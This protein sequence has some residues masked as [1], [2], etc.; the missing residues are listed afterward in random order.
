ME[1]RTEW[2]SK[3]LKLVDPD[4][5]WLLFEAGGLALAWGGSSLGARA[6]QEGDCEPFQELSLATGL[7]AWLAW[8]MEIDVRSAVERTS[9]IDLD[10]EDDPWRPIQVFAA[11]AGQLSSDLDA[12]ETFAG[13]VARTV[14][15]DV[16]TGSWIAAHLWL[17][18][19]LAHLVSGR[20]AFAKPA[21]APRP[22]DLILLGP[23]IDLRVR[24]AL[25]VVPAGAI[26]R[27]SVLAPEVEEGERQ[28]HSTHVQYLAWWEKETVIRQR[29]GS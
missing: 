22:G 2:R 20:E 14:R 4:H 1:Q 18:D 27:I 9:P 19:R 13:A 12:R 24:V 3:H 26:D 8:E 23:T 6:L 11:I 5:E 28:F 16:D 17:A 29:A 15:K 25:E 10:Q 7:L 21:R